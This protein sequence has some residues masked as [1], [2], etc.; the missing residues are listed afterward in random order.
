[1]KRTFPWATRHRLGRAGRAVGAHAHQARWLAGGRLSS[2]RGK[3]PSPGAVRR[4]VGGGGAVGGSCGAASPG[5]G[6]SWVQK[7]G[8]GGGTADSGTQASARAG[9]LAHGNHAGA[10]GHGMNRGRARCVNNQT[11]E[12]TLRHAAGLKINQCCFWG[13]SVT[14]AEESWAGNGLKSGGE[15][16]RR[17]G[18]FQRGMDSTRRKGTPPPSTRGGRTRDAMNW[19]PGAQCLRE[20]AAV[21]A[22]PWRT[23]AHA[24]TPLTMG[25][26]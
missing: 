6:V 4:R 15:G 23:R 1:M 18:E 17:G 25:S 19:R 9:M 26:M 24:S 13:C 12:G 8:R 5:A 20:T 16:G 10:Q 22:C 21:L 3:R 7:G 11:R 14:S 2:T